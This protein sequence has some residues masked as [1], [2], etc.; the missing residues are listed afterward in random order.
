MTSSGHRSRTLLLSQDYPDMLVV[1]RGSNKNDDAGT[2]V[3]ASGRSQL[4]A[5]NISSFSNRSSNPKTYEYLDGKL[6]G[7]GLRNSVGVAEHPD[8]G[9]I[10]SVENSYDKLKRDGKD[11]HND[12]PGE[13]MNF[14]GYLN[15]STA[16]RD[17]NYGYPF[18]LALWSTDNFPKLGDLKIG[19]QFAG[20][21]ESDRSRRTDR[22]CE[23]DYIAPVLAFQ[24]HTAPLDLKFNK[25]GTRAY[26]AFHGSC[27]LSSPFTP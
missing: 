17:S 15:G 18:C 10:F 4:R 3:L 23:R 24:A 25:N 19:E 14:H 1:S 5:F 13:E 9:G 11:I 27:K 21:R 6:L 7:W 2:E 8:T 20:D 26:V 22:E 16:S 12:N